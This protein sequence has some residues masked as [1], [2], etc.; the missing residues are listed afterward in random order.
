MNAEVT[1][2]SITTEDLAKVENTFMYHTP[3][4]DQTDRYFI[5]RADAKALALLVLR[6]CPPSRE[7]SLAL[8]NLEQ[9]AMWAN[10][11]IAVNE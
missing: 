7:R 5:L 1:E 8:T 4:G 10:K 9:A 2:Y 6:L 3:K 11:A